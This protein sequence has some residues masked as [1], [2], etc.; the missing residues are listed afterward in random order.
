MTFYTFSLLKSWQTLLLHSSSCQLFAFDMEITQKNSFTFLRA[1][2]S[3]SVAF[4][5]SRGLKFKLNFSKKKRFYFEHLPKNKEKNNIMQKRELTYVTM[6]IKWKNGGK[7]VL[8]NETCV[9]IKRSVCRFNL[10][11]ILMNVFLTMR[12][13]FHYYTNRYYD[14][15]DAVVKQ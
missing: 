2:S 14:A 10:Q 13:H 6:R 15:V 8:R 11:E 5:L 12:W 4:C 3:F 1:S 7:S 9:G